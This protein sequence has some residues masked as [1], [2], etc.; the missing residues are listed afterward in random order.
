MAGSTDGS[1]CRPAPWSPFEHRGDQT[2]GCTENSLPALRRAATLDGAFE[3]DLSAVL[4]RSAEWIAQAHTL[5]LRLIG[6]DAEDT[7][8]WQSA[9]DAGVGQVVD[10]VA[11]YRAWCGTTP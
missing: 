8:T 11:G 9:L 6:R 4:N 10:D 7:T 3:A 1:P 5:A 2:T